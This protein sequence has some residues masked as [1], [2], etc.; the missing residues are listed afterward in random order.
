MKKRIISAAI[1]I[2]IFVPLLII[3]GIPFRI[4]VGL[5][6]IL[7]Y[8]EIIELK[9]LKNYPL[10]VLIIGLLVLLLLIYSNRDILFITLGLN[11]KYIL[12]AFIA[13]FIPTIIYY[14]KEKYSVK[15]AFQLTSFIMFIGIIL[16]LMS[17]I[18]IYDKKYFIMLLLV[19]ILTDTFAYFTGVAIG[20][21]KFSKV[22]PNK[23]IEGCIGGIVM[24][25]ALSSIYYMTF[26]GVA[27]LHNV[28]F[29][30]L[31]LSIT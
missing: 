17:N 16:N 21:H 9:G 7:A 15:D 22:S 11:Y 3:G 29:V 18:L 6:G 1:L 24:G 26:I 4:A 30:L 25:T 8:K 19:T 23:S 27:P 20:R 2:L 28:I 31:L 10:P 12:F 13:M 14:G 5:I